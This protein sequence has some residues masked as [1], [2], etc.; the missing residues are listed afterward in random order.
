MADGGRVAE[1]PDQIIGHERLPLR[2][3]RNQ[4][5]DMFLQQVGGD[6]HSRLLVHSCFDYATRI[7][8]PILSKKNA[9]RIAKSLTIEPEISSYVDET[10]GDRSASERVNELLR[11]AMVQEQYERLG[12]KP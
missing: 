8:H 9:M 7:L 3:V 6:R 1:I 5:L 11:R 4:H 12:P 10:K 2:V